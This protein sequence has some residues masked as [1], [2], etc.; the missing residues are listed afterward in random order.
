LKN[1]EILAALNKITE[2]LNRFMD[3]SPGYRW[4]CQV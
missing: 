1:K 3:L 2:A 4:W